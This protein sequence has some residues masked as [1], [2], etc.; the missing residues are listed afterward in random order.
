MA[1]TSAGCVGTVIILMRRPMAR[2]FV[3]GDSDE[4]KAVLE[5]RAT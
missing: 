3:D 2:L 4:A 5:V 1:A